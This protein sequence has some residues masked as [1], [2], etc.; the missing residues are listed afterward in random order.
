M[1]Y[2]EKDSVMNEF[3]RL[4]LYVLKKIKGQNF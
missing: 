1:N 4:T 3:K 2:E